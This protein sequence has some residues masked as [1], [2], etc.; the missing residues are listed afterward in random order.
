MRYE[1]KA[2]LVPS[3]SLIGD[4]TVHSSCSGP[5]AWAPKS[6]PWRPGSPCV[7]LFASSIESSALELGPG[8]GSP[9]SLC[10][11]TLEKLSW[12]TTAILRTFSSIPG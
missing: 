10:Q 8:P 11:E 2:S 12:S 1:T 7:P 4:V 3:F 5:K 6:S 9:R